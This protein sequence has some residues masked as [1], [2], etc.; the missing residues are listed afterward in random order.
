MTVWTA[1]DTAS[2]CT[3]IDSAIVF[4]FS[5]DVPDVKKPLLA[6]IAAPR[7]ARIA[8]S[9]R[10]GPIAMPDWDWNFMAERESRTNTYF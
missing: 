9:N 3:M 7:M 2:A 1:V 5:V 6:A 10:I 4:A 8:M